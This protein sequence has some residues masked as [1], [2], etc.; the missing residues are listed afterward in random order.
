MFRNLQIVTLDFETYFSAEYSLKLK[1]YNTSSYIRDPQFKAQCVA[2]KV[3][4]RPVVWVAPNNLVAALATIDWNSS[5]LLCHNTAFDGLILSHHYGVEPAFYLD[6]LS[7][8]RAVH[9]NDIR[10]SLDAVAHY[11]GVGNK[12]K[13]CA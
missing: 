6:T 4:D 11:Y 2:I 13:K 3:E 7:M 1:K 10:N 9:D 8:A 12:L 5:A